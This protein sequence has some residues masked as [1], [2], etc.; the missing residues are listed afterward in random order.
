MASPGLR[1][2]QYSVARV[3]RAIVTARVG[4]GDWPWRLWHG[5]R[6]PQL[7][8]DHGRQEDELL[9]RSPARQGRADAA[10]RVPRARLGAS[11]ELGEDLRGGGGRPELVLP[12]HGARPVWQ[13][14]PCARLLAAAGA[15]LDGGPARNRPGHCARHG[16]PA[17][18][19]PAHLPSGSE[20]CKRAAVGGRRVRVHRQAGG[21]WHGDRDS[22]RQR[23]PIL[24][25]A[26]WRRDAVPQGTRGLQ[27]HLHVGQ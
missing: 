14:A 11:R 13:P 7:R 9:R 12:A 18:A 27:W 15:L 26:A 21:L 25:G 16:A 8:R 1:G 3:G 22:E 4:Q 23:V 20:G 6:G 2:A 5:A 24:L 17:S 19:P 10:P